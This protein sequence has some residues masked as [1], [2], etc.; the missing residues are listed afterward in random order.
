MQRTMDAILEQKDLFISTNYMFNE[1]D[2]G[3]LAG[4][5]SQ[6]RSHDDHS[7]HHDHGEQVKL[8]HD[9]LGSQ[10]KHALQCFIRPD[11]QTRASVP[12]R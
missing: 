2:Q 4:D 12:K 8:L 1:F 10:C 7:D 9:S 5:N 6:G 3:T 11:W